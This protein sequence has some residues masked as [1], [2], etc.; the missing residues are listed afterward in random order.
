M[1][2]KGKLQPV[3]I[4]QLMGRQADFNADGSAEAVR[5][6][7]E[8]FARGRE[9]YRTRQWKTAQSA[10]Q[11]LLEKWPKDGPAR[12]YAE[13]CQEYIAAEP[14]TNWDG[15]FVMTHK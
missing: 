5:Q 4:Y 13:R 14:P 2:V 12:V 8:L 15:V 10:F 9:L 3:T 6:Q 7:V 11:E 1:R